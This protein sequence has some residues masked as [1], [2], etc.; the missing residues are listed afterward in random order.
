MDKQLI[1]FLSFATK[2]KGLRNTD[3]KGAVIYTRVSTKEQADNNASLETQKKYC[4]LHAKKRELTIL[5]SFGGTYESA[6]S[7]ERKQFKLMLEYV[8]RQPEVAYIIVYSYDR[9][10]RTGANGSYITEQLKKRGILVVSATQE[11]DASTS[12]GSFQQDMFF[13]FSK[14]D[15]EIRRDK[16]VSGTREKLRKGYHA[17]GKPPFGYDNLNP[18]NGKYPDLR[19]N[20]YGKLLQEA[21]MLRYNYKM[22]YRDITAKLQPKGWDKGYKRLSDYLRNPFY[23]GLIISPML[24]GEIIE[25]KHPP[26]IA[27]EIFLEVNDLLTKRKKGNKYG[28]DDENL[29]L[30]LFVKAASCGTSY[31]GYLVK[32]KG[33]YYYKNNR[34]GSCENRSAKAMHELFEELLRYYHIADENYKVPLKQALIDIIEEAQG[35]Q[36]DEAAKIQAEVVKIESN[37]ELIE[38]RFV[39]EEISREL[40][41]KY[42]EQFEAD[43]IKKREECS[44]V[45]LDLSTLEYK[46]DLVIE[47]ALSLPLMWTF[48]DLEVKRRIQNM[49]F[50]SGLVYDHKKHQYRPERVNTLFVL[51]PD[52]LGVLEQ[53]ENGTTTQKELLSRI[54]GNDGFEPPT[55]CL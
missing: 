37:L 2:Q 29:P 36:M 39:L 50:P 4:E 7:D 35:D 22:S 47:Y 25:G 44:L 15:N 9:F 23:T 40:Y 1:P 30:K 18:G 11:V 6:K 55:S 24:P 54:V 19:I 38:K 17:S 3:R 21:F 14:F 41:L 33:N 43:L 28:A 32:A 49:L 48:G 10:S 13:L 12:A 27:R 42:R 5:K 34:I 53:K 45:A 16:C 46:I 8:K 52:I 51:I 26:L 31:T 20:H